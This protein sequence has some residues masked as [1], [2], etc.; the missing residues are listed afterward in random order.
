MARLTKKKLENRDR[1]GKRQIGIGHELSILRKPYE[2]TKR[3]RMLRQ[4]TLTNL[5]QQG[6][7]FRQYDSIWNR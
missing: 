1:K 4:R 2:I 5:R 7:Q 3:V 6:C